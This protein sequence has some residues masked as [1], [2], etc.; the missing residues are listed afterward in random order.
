MALTTLQ[1]GKKG[2]TQEFIENLRVAFNQSE[3]A[4]VNILK[5]ATRDKKQLKEW[6]DKIVASLGQN[7]TYK[8]IGYTIVIRKWRKTFVR[9]K[10]SR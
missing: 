5:S 10:D 3:H 8:T 2:L 4:R 7:F 6:A 1:I 9:D